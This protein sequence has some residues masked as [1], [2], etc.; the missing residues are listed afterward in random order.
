MMKKLLLIVICF[1]LVGCQYGRTLF[2]ATDY[3]QYNNHG[4]FVSPLENIEGYKYI[5]LSSILIEES[6]PQERYV[7]IMLDKMVEYAKRQ[8]ANGLIGFK[9]HTS[10]ISSGKISVPIWQ[11]TGI[12][13]KFIGESPATGDMLKTYDFEAAKKLALER[14]V[15]LV[16]KYKDRCV[17]YDP[18]S[19]SYLYFDVFLERYGR[20]A[21][22]RLL[23][24]DESIIQSNEN[25]V[26]DE[27]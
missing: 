2:Y 23:Q 11:A 18:E 5:P 19:E 25:A 26:H 7:D 21:Y 14:G 8:G 20:S 24:M 6:N 15:N 1:V 27:D 13:I 9:F 10:S 4:F 3:T 16:T 12:A 22:E 17:C